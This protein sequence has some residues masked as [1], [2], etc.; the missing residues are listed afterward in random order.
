MPSEARHD[1]AI[2]NFEWLDAKEAA[3]YLKVKDTRTFLR[4]VREGKFIGYAVSG[5]KRHIW[6]FLKRDLDA[7]LLSHPVVMSESPTVLS[8]ERRAA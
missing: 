2:A 6:R 8:K 5:T 1:G 3:E 4:W 7:A